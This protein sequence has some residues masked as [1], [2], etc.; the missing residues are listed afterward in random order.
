MSLNSSREGKKQN[1]SWI[2]WEVGEK[3]NE[4]VI[5]E[6]IKRV[7]RG[8]REACADA[9][10]PYRTVA[11]W[12]K[13]FRKGRDLVQDNLRTG[14][15]RVEDNTVQLLASLLDADHLWTVR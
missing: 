4:G 2:P 9:A 13:T 11:Q 5:Q 12:V 1:E 8:L 6:R 7:L 3:R 10:L 14:R 15:P